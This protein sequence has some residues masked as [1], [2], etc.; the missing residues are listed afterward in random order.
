M[1]VGIDFSKP[2]SFSDITV[3]LA[4]EN[5]DAFL[6]RAQKELPA[7]WL[8]RYLATQEERGTA[9]PKV[10]G[11]QA[12]PLDGAVWFNTDKSQMSLADFRGKYVL[13]DFWAVW[14]GP[15]HADF[16]EVKLLNEMYK[17]RGLVVIG[18]HDNSVD[19]DSVRQH[20]K[21]QGLTFPIVVD[22]RDGTT[23]DA[24]G[25]IGAVVGF[26][27]YVLIGPDGKIVE[28]NRMSF[29]K[30]EYIRKHLFANAD[31]TRAADSR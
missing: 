9:Q 22:R 18:V 8:K 3:K 25:K 6:Q 11:Q 2:E 31:S 10:I 4:P 12:P 13:L 30:F 1:R 15:C 21:E 19:A 5:Y 17:D 28:D 24:Y 23:V 16:P 29:Y 26:P 14:C 7:Q 20:A 27:N